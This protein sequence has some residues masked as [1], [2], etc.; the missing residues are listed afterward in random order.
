MVK[1]HRMSYDVV[2]GGFSYDDIK[3]IAKD[4]E[5][6]IE[7]VTNLYKKSKTATDFENK[8]SLRATHKIHNKTH[9]KTCN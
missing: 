4:F 5:L 1:A 9:S 3:R 8:K 6:T 2:L 7:E